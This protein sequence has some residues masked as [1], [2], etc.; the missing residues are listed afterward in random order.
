MNLSGFCEVAAMEA[1]VGLY[2]ELGQV[3]LHT[4]VTFVMYVLFGFMEIKF[5][6]YR[7]IPRQS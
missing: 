3:N 6:L 4:D 7:M 2:L 5:S 1:L